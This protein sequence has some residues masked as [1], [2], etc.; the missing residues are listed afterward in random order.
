MLL[1]AQGA[2][3]ASPSERR[4]TKL[5]IT[6]FPPEAKDE[7]TVRA[8][9]LIAMLSRITPTTVSIVHPDC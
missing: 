9:L 4:R 5:A 7:S 2:V 3:F 8:L 6:C 1:E